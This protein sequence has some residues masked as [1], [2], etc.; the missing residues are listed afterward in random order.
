[1]AAQRLG[2]PLVALFGPTEPRRTGSCGRLENVLRI[3]LPCSPCFK[4][5]C[6][7]KNPNECLRAI[8]PAQALAQILKF[9]G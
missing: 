9:L 6:A 3:E 7:W 1:V 4:S 8:S 5:Y 2:K